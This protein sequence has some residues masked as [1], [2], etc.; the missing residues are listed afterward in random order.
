MDRVMAAMVARL[1]SKVGLA[2]EERK[3]VLF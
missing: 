3:Y 2:E 1:V